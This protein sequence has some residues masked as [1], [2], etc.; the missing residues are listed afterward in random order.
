MIVASSGSYPVFSG[1]DHEP[2][3]L[4]GGLT[5]WERRVG[6]EWVGQLGLLR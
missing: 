3:P 6:R 1:H 2:D 4:G 5:W